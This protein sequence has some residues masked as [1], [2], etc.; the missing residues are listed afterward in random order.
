MQLEL[1]FSRIGKL[2]IYIIFLGVLLEFGS[3]GALKIYYS[4]FKHVNA[5]VVSNGVSAELEKVQSNNVFFPTRWYTN[6]L[7]F[8]GKYVTTDAS[9]FRID[10]NKVRQTAAIGFFGGSTMFSVVTKQSETIPDQ[11]N[12]NGFDSLNF[13][14]GGYSSTA[15]LPTFIEAL[16]KHPSIK[17]AVFYDGVNEPGRY[18]ELFQDDAPEDL[19]ESVGY[20]YKPSIDSS[21]MN[22]KNTSEFIS[23]KSYFLELWSRI[24]AKLFSKS[25]QKRNLDLNK[26]STKIANNYLTNLDYIDS[27]AKNKKIKVFFFWQPNIFTTKKHLTKLESSILDKDKSV[28]PLLTKMV[29]DKVMSDPRSKKF[30][31]IDLTSSL[32]ESNQEIFYDWCHLNGHG[33]QII[34]EKIKFFISR[35]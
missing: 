29:R 32:D 35:K 12:L 22:F 27:I 20:Y 15:E 17:I 5:N 30:N 4:M 8:K 7:N 31:V 25:G 14:I 6:M 19:F 11:V 23:F 34:A 26:Y 16:N 24:G 13:G 3:W 21:I 2:T 1:F 9:G 28:M 10:D 18:V 33:N